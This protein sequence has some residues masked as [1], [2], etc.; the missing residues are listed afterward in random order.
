MAWRSQLAQ[1]SASSTVG[2]TLRQW[3]HLRR[4]QSAGAANQRSNGAVH[5][6]LN[7]RNS[8][9]SAPPTPLDCRGSYIRGFPRR[10]G[11]LNGL[12]QPTSSVPALLIERSKRTSITFDWLYNYRKGARVGRK[13]REQAESVA[14]ESVRSTLI[15]AATLMILAQVGGIG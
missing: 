12:L 14:G 8:A 1:C 15:G 3:A 2:L 13:L 10:N 4:K 7:S 6:P 5:R 11:H 9:K